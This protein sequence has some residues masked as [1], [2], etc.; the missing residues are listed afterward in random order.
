[1]ISK[2]NNT[3]HRSIEIKPVDEKLGT[4]INFV[5]KSSDKGHKLE[6][7]DHVRKSKYKKNTEKEVTLQRHSQT[8]FR[9]E[10]GCKKKRNKLHVK[11]KGYDNW[12]NNWID[13]KGIFR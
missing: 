8:E 1:M 3:Y 5:V 9:I 10:R 13:K 12:F 6:I 7:G 11:W 4:Y 2:Y